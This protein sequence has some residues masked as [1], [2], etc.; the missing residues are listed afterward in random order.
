MSVERDC[1]RA[2][3]RLSEVARAG[4]KALRNRSQD[5]AFAG[6]CFSRLSRLLDRPVPDFLALS[7]SIASY[8]PLPHCR[9]SFSELIP[10]S[11]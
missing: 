2:S 7:N 10:R 9:I 8:L 5:Q 4:E 6:D 3:D 1:L 11:V